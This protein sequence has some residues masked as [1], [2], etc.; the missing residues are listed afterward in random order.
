[1]GVGG[2][3]HATRLYPLERERIPFVKQ[4][5]LTPD[6][7]WMGGENLAPP[8][9]FDPRTLQPI[10]SQLNP[11]YVILKIILENERHFS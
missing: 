2:Q 10:A 6:P 11:T 8:T 5:I 7:P 3:S 9:R 4:V 1:M